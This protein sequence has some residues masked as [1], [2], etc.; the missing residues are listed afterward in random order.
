[1]KQIKSRIFFDRAIV[2][3]SFVIILGLVDFYIDDYIQYKTNSIKYELMDVRITG[4]D[5]NLYHH[6]LDFE[7]KINN[8]IYSGYAPGYTW[9]HTGDTIRVAVNK[10]KPYIC[11]RPCIVLSFHDIFCLLFLFSLLL[12]CIKDLCKVKG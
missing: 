6:S 10:E 2:V 11:I 4:V 8:D 7:Y 1:M 3:L 9:E 12:G 5:A